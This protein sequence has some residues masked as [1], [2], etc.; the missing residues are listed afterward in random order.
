MSTERDRRQAKKREK[1]KKKRDDARRTRG[2]RRPPESGGTADVSEALAW[3]VGDAWISENW[4][5]RGAHAHALFT[6]RHESGRLAVSVFEADLAERG[7]VEARAVSGVSEGAVQ[8]ELVRRS[9]DGRAM[10]AA[11]PALVV[12]LVRVAADHGTSRGHALPAGYASALSLFGDVRAADAPQEILTGT[13]DAPAEAAGRQ[14]GFLA[15]LKRRLG[16]GGS[17]R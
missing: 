7:I 4:H 12:K 11:E 14:E 17:T 2:S 6:R 15:T 8:G 16:L 13:E 5:E 9:S 3:P 1:Q 10:V